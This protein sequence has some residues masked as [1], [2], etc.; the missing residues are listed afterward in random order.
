MASYFDDDNRT[1]GKRPKLI[2]F[3]AVALTIAFVFFIVLSRW[4]Y[5]T[6]QIKYTDNDENIL[7][8]DYY[9][10]N[11]DVLKVAS[12]TASY[13]DDSN[14]SFWTVAYNMT[15]PKAVFAGSSAAIYDLGGN[16]LVICDTGGLVA[17]VKPS[18]PVVKAA[19]SERSGAAVILD[20]GTDAWIEYYDSSGDRISSIKTT[21][22]DTGYP[23]RYHTDIYY[24]VYGTW[25]S[26][27]DN[28]AARSYRNGNK[29]DKRR[30]WS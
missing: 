6:Y 12:D 27:P 3:G 22:D 28:R 26:C 11:G 5:K 25:R 13:I 9:A 29:R 10:F 15:Q 20:D 1:A 7:A 24:H 18:M 19:V 4:N 2:L 23:G 8:Y 17:T 21:M 16:T 30:V 14:N